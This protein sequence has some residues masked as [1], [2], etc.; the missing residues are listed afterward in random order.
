MTT[1]I[2]KVAKA[3]FE[4]AVTPFAPWEEQGHDAHIY[5][6]KQARAA[7][8]AMPT[9]CWRCNADLSDPKC[10]DCEG[11]G[12]VRGTSDDWWP[13]PRC[14]KPPTDEALK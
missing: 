3:I 9:K 14:A 1:I 8:A 7:I 5:W 6:G 10:P 13:C 11:S 4:N 2:E 12:K